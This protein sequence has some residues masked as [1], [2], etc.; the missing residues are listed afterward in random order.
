MTSL[1]VSFS[2]SHPLSLP[3]AAAAVGFLFW[4]FRS[5][6]P[7]VASAG[8]F[9]SKAA[10]CQFGDDQGLNNMGAG[11]DRGE[12]EQGGTTGQECPQWRR[13]STVDDK[14]PAGMRKGA[15]LEICCPESDVFQ[16]VNA[17]S[18]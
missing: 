11:W 9:G 3:F 2:S 12:R 5:R 8:R 1:P 10:G 7:D 4:H 6:P 18:F 13:R 14:R 17:N 15:E 16:F